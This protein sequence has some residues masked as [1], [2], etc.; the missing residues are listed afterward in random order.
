[1]FRLA[2]TIGKT[3]GELEREM[4]QDE[5]IYWMAYN[6]I[7]PLPDPWLETGIIAS[8][9]ANAAGPKKPFK[10]SD[11]MPKRVT[12]HRATTEEIRSKISQYKIIYFN[13]Y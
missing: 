1:V 4:T 9:V 3:V 5:L 13:Q 2:S 8:T 7:D 10:P 6:Q 12:F 11:Y